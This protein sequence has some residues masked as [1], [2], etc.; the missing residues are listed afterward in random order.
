MRTASEIMFAIETTH[1]EVTLSP[2]DLL[3]LV[4]EIKKLEE[5]ADDAADERR[6]NDR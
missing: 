5:A 6:F 1:G 3:V 4:A 2:G